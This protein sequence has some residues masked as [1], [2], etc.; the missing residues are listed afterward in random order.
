MRW[1]L[2]FFF[3]RGEILR[4]LVFFACLVLVCF[5]PRFADRTFSA[6]EE[7]GSRLAE[8]KL[9]AVF[10][11]ALATI[12]IRLSF[13]WLLPVPYPQV[14]DEFSYLLAGDTFVHGRLTNP[15]HPMSLYLDTF[16]VNQHPTYMSKYP[17]G[18]GLALA[19]GQVLSNPWI[20]VLLSG[21]AMCAA[22]LWM[23]QGWL[24]PRWALVGGVL[25]MFKIALFSYW[26][27]GYL[28][29][30][31]AAIGGALAVGA[32]PRI[33]HR[34]QWW[35]A[36]ILGIGAVILA[37]SRPFEGAF[38][39]LPIFVVLLVRLFRGSSPSWRV[40]LT[41][42]VIPLCILGIFGGAFMGYYN[43]RG[44]GS[45][46]LFPYAVNEKTYMRT[47]TFSWQKMRPPIHY[48]NPQFEQFYNGAMQRWWSFGGVTNVSKAIQKAGYILGFS[49][50][51]FAWPQLSVALLA[52][53]RVLRDRR[54][55]LL[56]VQAA[57]VFSSFML[58]RAFFNLHYAAPLVAT[59]FALLTQGLRH[60]RH[61]KAWG[62]PVGIGITRVVV[63]FV[64]LLAFFSMD[65]E[66]WDP[67]QFRLKFASQLAAMPGQHLV[68]V[69]YSPE[70][71]PY[72][73][74]VYNGADIDGSRV[75][76][77]REIPG[78]SL[79]PLLDY[80]RGRQ[81]WLAEPD[82]SP[83]RLSRYESR[84]P[85]QGVVPAARSQG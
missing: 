28:G 36:V 70:H 55:R 10:A 17:P 6:I 73:E 52:S 22:A 31:V 50:F 13:F 35:D 71:V 64:V 57:L 46:T 83:S 39:C 63:L 48:A 62:R 18:Q 37:N 2:H 80:F 26:M 56:L 68:I 78:V 29:G 12:V 60:V 30:F 25:V 53:L 23:L 20:G 84:V 66:P 82:T 43:W 34:W 8:R 1:L 75:V 58:V 41:Q 54:V 69:R 72:R 77:A 61:W 32:L 7:F 49:M 5:V 40:K 81:V 65:R 24:P 19:L 47:P 67:I 4:D 42:I 51:F 9:I 21:A 38:F 76:W 27:N 59:I 3:S 11:I 85:P 45:A 15:P 14:H 33:L 44:T 79:Q 16:N 74:W